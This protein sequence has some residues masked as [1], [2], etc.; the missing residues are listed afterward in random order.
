MP[1]RATASP[2]FECKDIR[3]EESILGDKWEAVYSCATEC[4]GEHFRKAMMNI[5]RQPNVNSTVILRADILTEDVYSRDT[6]EVQH[7]I[8]EG[9]VD[10]PEIDPETMPL[11]VNPDDTAPRRVEMGPLGDH[12]DVSFVRRIVPRNPRRDAVTNQTCLVYSGK[13]GEDTCI[14]VYITHIDAIDQCPY[15]LPPARGVAIAYHK[16]EL[17]VHYLLFDGSHEDQLPV[18]ERDSTERGLRIAYR[19][20]QTSHK[21]SKGVM[22]GYKKRVNHDVVVDKVGFQDTYILLKQKYAKTLVANWAESTDP[23]K[24]VFEDLSI[25]AFLIQLWK[26]TY[27]SKDIFE[28]LDL[29]CGNGLLVHILLQEGYK[30]YGIDVRARKSWSVYGEETA[31][32]LKEQVVIPKS[33]LDPTRPEHQKLLSDPFVN[34]LDDEE[35]P[36]NTFLIGNHSDEL[37]V[38]IPLFNRPF[39]VIPCCSHALNGTKHRYP[40]KSPE[41]KSGYAALVDHVEFIAEKV[42]WKVEKERLRIPSTRNAAVIGREKL[43]NDVSIAQAIADEGG[44]EGWAKN[45]MALR[46]KKPRDH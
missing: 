31:E 1:A 3:A 21:H 4:S 32:C 20:L 45:T 13:E 26:Q 10:V 33:I 44:A 17:S 37:T 34:V 35:M 11:T 36:K 2:S 7:L 19:L 43:H 15:Y 8:P 39:M 23:N 41:N 24:H 40:A 16:N 9:S 30:G 14:V 25:A 29:G 38:W 22:E 27:D 46:S 6:N 5:I 42:G 28:F 18:K 12:L